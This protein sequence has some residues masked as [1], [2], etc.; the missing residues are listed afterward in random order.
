MTAMDDIRYEVALKMGEIEKIIQRYGLPGIRLLTLFA[1]DPDNPN[2]YL[3]ISND[4]GCAPLGGNS[5]AGSWL[6]M[7]KKDLITRQLLYARWR[8][9]E[10]IAERYRE[11]LNKH[12]TA[13]Q[14]FGRRIGVTEEQLQRHDA[15]KWEEAEFVPYAR[16]FI[17]HGGSPVD[18]P[19]VTDAFAQAWL[20]HL[21]HNPHHWQH[22]IFPD[23]YVPHGSSVERDGVMEMPRHFALEMIADWHG[24][25]YAYNGS[26][27]IANWLWN[28]MPRI[29][30]HSRTAA[31]LRETLDALGYADV[32]WM[33]KFA[34][35]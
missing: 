6:E 16:Y 14:E 25:E 19:D 17:E 4:T 24:A 18:R 2:M 26:W 5:A 27:D 34:E 3:H 11:R 32:V 20:H 10:Q 29:R 22:W 28:M 30:V 35:E 21:H 9:D 7:T 15:S 1:R 8:I 12:I 31:F 23:G 33:R 13:V